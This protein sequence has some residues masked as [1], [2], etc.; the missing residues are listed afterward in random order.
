MQLISSD[1]SVWI[2]FEVVDALAEPFLLN[3]CYSFL[4][5]AE[6]MDA[7]LQY[8]SNLSARLEGYGL[9]RTEL[10]DEEYLLALTLG[11][12]YKQLSSYD[13][14]ALAIAQNRGIPILTGDG[15]LRKAAEKEGIEFHGTLWVIDR[16]WEEKAI[17]QQRYKEIL[18]SLKSLCGGAVRLP[19][20]EIDHRLE[21][22]E[23][24]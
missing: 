12:K 17:T 19:L 7:E 21:L 2:D 24:I 14:F 9:V 22:L 13:T 20:D 18:C 11:S 6:T 8:P 23:G 4:M 3:S 16:L 15:A 5:S 10:R 1:T